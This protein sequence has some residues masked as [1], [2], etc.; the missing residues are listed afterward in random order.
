MTTVAERVR[1][2]F[3]LRDLQARRSGLSAELHGRT[4]KSSRVA[5]RRREAAEALWLAGFPAEAL[6]LAREAVELA[7]D[8]RR[9]AGLDAGPD[10]DERA[11]LP[12]QPTLPALDDEVRPEHA[13]RFRA[14][15]ERQIQLGEANPEL[16]LDAKQ[17]TRLRF[18]RIGGVAV[19]ALALVGLTA[20]VVRGPR[21]LRAKV[22]A[23]YDNHFEAPNAVDGNEVTEWLLPDRAPGWIEVEVIPRRT[24]KRVK[25]M[26]ARNKPF[27]DRA[28]KEFHV[29]LLDRGKVVK[30]FDG[31]FDAYSA[32]PTWRT[33]DAGIRA[34]AV[35]V[36]VR[37]WFV[38]GGGLAE[39]QV[40]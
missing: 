13:A 23:S 12:S 28:T 4:A 25:L 22:S 30:S 36:E 1:E 34:D 20:F 6:R 16:E 35:R 10:V 17:I 18:A 3:L 19:A 37:S 2:W 32:E 27:A 14:L 11:A 21:L 9:D 5:R 15:V 7:R 31:Q 26:N 24:L 8:A 40:E 33:L 39:I 29:D 38:T